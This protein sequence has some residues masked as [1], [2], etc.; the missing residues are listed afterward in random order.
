MKGKNVKK[1]Y[2]VAPANVNR[3][4]FIVG[5]RT[6]LWSLFLGLVTDW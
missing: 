6:F 1:N 3:A 5:I 2:G 4:V